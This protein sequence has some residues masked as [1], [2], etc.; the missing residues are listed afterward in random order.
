MTICYLLDARVLQGAVA[1]AAARRA[2]TIAAPPATPGPGVTPPQPAMPHWPPSPDVLPPDIEDPEP[3]EPE[4]PV[5]EPP[6]VMLPR[7]I[8]RWLWYVSG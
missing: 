5:D 7:P 3:P 1:L 8:A 2:G 4:P 6:Q